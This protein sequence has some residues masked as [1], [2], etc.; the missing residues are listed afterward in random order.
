M[1]LKTIASLF[2]RNKRLE[3]LTAENGEQW[4]SNGHAAYSLRGMPHMTP[5]IVLRIFDV[6][7]DKHSK[8]LCGESALPTAINFEDGATEETAIEPMRMNIEWYGEN[9]WLFPDGRRIYS[10]NEC[11]IKPLLARVGGC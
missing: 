2:N 5:E 10:F 7:P 9:F 1:K 4:I 6:P 11:Y 8:W 3:I